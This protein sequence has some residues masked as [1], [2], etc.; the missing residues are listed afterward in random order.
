MSALRI[1]ET[2]NPLDLD[3]ALEEEEGTF[4]VTR[5]GQTYLVVVKNGKVT[6][7]GFENSQRPRTTHE[8]W[9]VKK[10]RD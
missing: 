10:V 7:P 1:G 4:E 8:R 6:W 2:S 9:R 3:E 5:E